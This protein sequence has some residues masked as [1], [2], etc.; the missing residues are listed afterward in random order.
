VLESVR[1]FGSLRIALDLLFRIVD[2]TDL[3]CARPLCLETV[4]MHLEPRSGEPGGSDC[5]TVR[6]E[7][8][9]EILGDSYSRVASSC[10]PGSSSP[11]PGL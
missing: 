7:H 11:V 4:L 6:L 8:P 10:V 1:V 3:P 9:L 5:D 2:L